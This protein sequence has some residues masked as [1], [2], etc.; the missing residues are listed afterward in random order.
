[1]KKAIIIFLLSFI[2]MTAYSQQPGASLPVIIP[3]SPEGSSLGKYINYPVSYGTGLPSIEIPLYEIK[4]GDLTLPISLSY[5]ASGLKVNE[6][7]GW[8]GAGWSLNAEPSVSRSIKGQPDE[9]G[10]LHF[11]FPLPVTKDYYAQLADNF[12]DEQPDEFYYKLLSKSGG[13]YFKKPLQDTSSAYEVL[14]HPFD[15]IKIMFNRLTPNKLEIKDENGVYYRFG[16]S[17]N[18]DLAMEYCKGQRNNWRATE[19]ISSSGRDTLAFKYFANLNE[20][21]H[22]NYDVIT[23]EDS[24]SNIYLNRPGCTAAFPLVDDLMGPSSTSYSVADGGAFILGCSVSG[25][26]DDRGGILQAI[27]INEIN[28]KNGKVLFEKT[29]E[30][31]ASIKIYNNT[32]LLKQIRFYRSYYPVVG[33]DPYANKKSRLDSIQILDAVGNVVQHYKFDY[34]NTA[35]LPD[36]FLSKDIDYWGYYNG[37]GNDPAKSLV[38]VTTVTAQG[39]TSRPHVTFQIGA[40]NREP[41][42]FYMQAGVLTRITYPTGGATYFTYEA[43]RYL[44]KTAAGLDTIKIAGGLRVKTIVDADPLSNDI[45]REFKYGNAESGAGFIKNKITPASF[46]YRQQNLYQ[47]GIAENN[48]NF[49]TNLRTY[50]SNSLTD[51][52]YSDGPPVVYPEVTEYRSSTTLGA[53]AQGMGKTI[54]KYAYDYPAALLTFP[55][56]TIY[57]DP[58]TDWKFGHLLSQE[59]YKNDSG[60]FKLIRRKGYKTDVTTFKQNTIPLSGI[61][62]YVNVTFIDMPYSSSYESFFY[63]PFMNIETGAKRV[64]SDTTT[65]IEGTQTL[66]TVND[67][68]YGNQ[69]NLMPTQTVTTTSDGQTITTTTKYPHDV[70][71]SG[72]AETARQQLISDWRIATPLEQTTTKGGKIQS[73]KTDYD[74]FH[75]LAEVA[76]V[77]LNTGASH[78]D[79]PRIR[80]SDYNNDGRPLTLSKVDG[81][82]KGYI[83]GYKNQYPVAEAS[84]APAN[85]IYYESFEEGS[86]NSF[87][88]DSK[89]GHYS[90]TGSYIK[91]LTGLDAGQYV[92]S[93]WQKGTDWTL[94]KSVVTVSSSSYTITL[95]ANIQI[96][97]LRFYPLNAQMTTYTYDPLIGM[98]SVTD[99][100]D[101]TS[102][103]EYDSFNRLRIIKDQQRHILKAYCYNY[104]GEATN[105][106]VPQNDQ[107]QII[108]A[109]LEMT[110]AQPG[111]YDYDSGVD[112]ESSETEDFYIRFYAD[113]ACTIP[114]SLPSDITVNIAEMY[115]TSDSVNGYH[116]YPYTNVY[117]V[118]ANA[119]EYYIGNLSTYDDSYAITY[120][121][122]YQYWNYSWDYS[123]DT[124]SYVIEPAIYY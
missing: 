58:K 105:C 53:A 119:T 16:T 56:T 87:V 117:N 26:G 39:E 121:S 91:S 40:A 57:P 12:R 103:Y 30:D 124:G 71:L 41:N 115:S 44:D 21:I 95:P 106:L 49:T 92:L 120:Y 25:I 73:I 63:Y 46:M 65:V 111:P 7:A 45:Y 61:F 35:P 116:I 104:K 13:F 23:V 109:R 113:A 66:V 17:L 14:T 89:A 67:Y 99:A 70:A 94:Q 5:H 1:M 59:D 28:F 33:S 31:L 19:V 78:G 15:P 29:D 82:A 102:Y 37:A 80:Y 36:R 81:P 64:V 43:N 27:K 68:T 76:T 51:L 9:D 84:N 86:G 112:G 38:P 93:Y 32:A 47:Y 97:E 100:K 88:N 69:E 3:A 54:Y 2:Q 62:R 10:Y 55:G 60:T 96:D 114:L 22:N 4:S 74:I 75:G 101:M 11:D 6:A 79:E 90:Y 108:Y 77:K 20:D 42:E 98:T 18:N 110:N 122:N 8:I 52:F 72:S 85:D 118:P 34:N 107:P 48:T 50:S 83:W 24:T 123:L